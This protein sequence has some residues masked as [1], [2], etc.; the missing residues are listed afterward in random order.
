MRMLRQAVPDFSVKI[1]DNN[2]G[3]ALF[4]DIH[5]AAWFCEQFPHY[6]SDCDF[7]KVTETNEFGFCLGKLQ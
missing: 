7:I 4:K 1:D 3:Y 5:S 6:F 2:V